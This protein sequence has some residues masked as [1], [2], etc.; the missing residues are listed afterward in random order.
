MH[1]RRTS[2]CLPRA[3]AAVALLSF[4]A[5]PAL[6]AQQTSQGAHL[7]SPDQLQ[8]QVQTAA[9]TRQDNIDNLTRFLSTPTAEKAMRDTKI[10]PV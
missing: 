4:L 6:W 2:F 1:S 7:V 10:D 9:A 8:Q 5:T 3:F